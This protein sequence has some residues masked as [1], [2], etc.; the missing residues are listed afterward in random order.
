MM[1][2]LPV[3]CVGGVSVL[4]PM[5]HRVIGL[6]SEEDWPRESPISYTCSWCLRD[7]CTQLLSNLGQEENNLLLV[8]TIYTF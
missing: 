7:P 5:S 1:C 8:C 6:S 4:F 2:V 3:P